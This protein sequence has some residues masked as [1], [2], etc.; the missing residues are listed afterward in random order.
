MEPFDPALRD[1]NAAC[2]QAA[3]DQADFDARQ[4][5][6]ASDYAILHGFAQWLRHNAMDAEE[7]RCNEAAWISF[8][9]GEMY[10]D[11]NGAVITKTR[12]GT[13][14]IGAVLWR[15]YQR[16]KPAKLVAFQAF[17]GSGVLEIDGKL[18][19]IDWPY[20]YQNENPI[21]AGQV[22]RLLI[23][24][25][26]ERCELEFANTEAAVAFLKAKANE[27]PDPFANETE[28][29]ILEGFN[30]L[31]AKNLSGIV[32]AIERNYIHMG[33]HDRAR[34]GLSRIL[35]LETTQNSPKLKA[36]IEELLKM[37]EE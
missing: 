22:E 32:D 20:S 25:D 34:T 29:S 10:L 30:S 31:G 6:I 33:L 15:L 26:Y 7:D 21:T 24:M 1:E 3:R 2:D 8:K 4:E 19:Y 27:G 16:Q 12:N 9:G 13:S 18:T 14:D 37:I 17:E 35:Q 11:D 23:R 36:K 28:E 5:R